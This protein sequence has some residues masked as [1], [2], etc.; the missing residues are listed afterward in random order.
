MGKMV[1]TLVFHVAHLAR[2]RDQAL[3]KQKWSLF[4]LFF[5]FGSHLELMVLQ[6][7]IPTTNL[8]ARR[9]E[10]KTSHG[11]AP[12]DGNLST[13]SL[14]I[15]ANKYSKGLTFNIKKKKKKSA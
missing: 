14:Q 1:Q 8:I 7:N 9:N 6:Y 4:F 3:N 2:E 11:T 5:F 10:K 12:Q 15:S 13:H